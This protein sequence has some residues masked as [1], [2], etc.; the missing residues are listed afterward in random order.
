M[1]IV[2]VCCNH[3]GAPLEVTEGTRFVTCQFCKTKLAVKHTNST[4]FTEAIEQ[5]AEA[6]SRMAENLEVIEIQNDIEKLDRE[7]GQHEVTFMVKT[8]NGSDRPG[9]PTG[10]IIGAVV[11]VGF[12]IFW[13]GGASSIG[14]PTPFVLFGLIMLVALVGST[15]SSIGKF[16]ARESAHDIYQKRRSLLEARLLQARSRKPGGEAS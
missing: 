7:W 15:V 2:S 16:N 12:L 14:A 13:I 8:K 4:V 3:C 1:E 5:I 11:G 9:S 6:T 10:Q